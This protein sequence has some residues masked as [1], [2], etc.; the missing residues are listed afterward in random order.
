MFA[1]VKPGDERFLLDHADFSV[2]S[3]VAFFSLQ[4]HGDGQLATSRADG[5]PTARWADWDGPLMDQI[6][7]RAH[8]AGTRVVLTVRSFGWD[9]AGQ[10]TSARLLSDP[11]SRQTLA[12]QITEA[13]VARGVDGVNVD[14]EPIPDGQSATFVDFIRELRATLDAAQPGLQLTFDATGYIANYDISALTAPGAADAVYV[15]GYQYSGTW[16]QHTG[17]MAPLGG[18][19]Y[20]LNDTLQ[21]FLSQ[22]TADKI[23]LGLPVFGYAWSTTSSGLHAATQPKGATFGYP[24]QVNLDVATA[25]AAAHGRSWDAVEEAPWSSWR[26]RACGTCPATW[27]E[28]YYEDL[29]SLRLK[30]DLVNANGLRGVGVWSYGLQGSSIDLDGLLREE[31]VVASGPA[32][33]PG[34]GGTS[35]PSPVRPGP[36]RV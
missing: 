14:F 2:I 9:V 27:R 6:I 20:D 12:R 4:V 23:I 7:D 18:P 11:A 22:T 5:A 13:V 19:S 21:A 30:Y 15:M 10:Q 16:S 25:I 17:A 33:G 36:G 3:T 34:S 1:F 32:G 26:F 8:A 31:F 28:V 24:G 35:A 29:G